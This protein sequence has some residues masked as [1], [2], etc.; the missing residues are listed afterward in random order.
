M[1]QSEET[2]SG[3]SYSHEI[4]E[5]WKIERDS[6]WFKGKKLRVRFNT[7]M[8][9]KLDSIWFQGKETKSEI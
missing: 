9:S 6:I 4:Q 3:T 5:R 7:S 2:K 1:I 8:I